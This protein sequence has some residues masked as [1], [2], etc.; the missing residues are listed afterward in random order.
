[1]T[2]GALTARPA[3][4]AVRLTAEAAVAHD[5]RG[6]HAE[7]DDAG[8]DLR[9]AEHSRVKRVPEHVSAY[10]GRDPST[11]WRCQSAGAGGASQY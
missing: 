2:R 3:H 6:Q 10:S 1:M 5:D 8:V 9:L 11:G 4:N 7:L